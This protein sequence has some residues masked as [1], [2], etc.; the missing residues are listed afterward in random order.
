MLSPPTSFW[1]V[2]D[3]PVGNATVSWQ[4][5]HEPRYTKKHKNAERSQQ[6]RKNRGGKRNS[7]VERMKCHRD[8]LSGQGYGV[9]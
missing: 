8:L 7:T 2:T 1:N 4:E 9:T 5:P 3:R 6:H